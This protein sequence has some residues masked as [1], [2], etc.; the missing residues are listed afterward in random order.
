M[1]SGKDDRTD[2]IRILKALKLRFW[3]VNNIVLM[4]MEQDWFHIQN[5]KDSFKLFVEESSDSA[6][7]VL[8]PVL[9]GNQLLLIEIQSL[10][11]DQAYSYPQKVWLGINKQKL[12]IIMATL[13][14]SLKISDLKEKDLFVKV[15][16][17]F[18][19]K[20]IHLD[21]AVACSIISSFFNI[22]FKE[23]IFIGELGLSWEI[24]SIPKQKE[25]KERLIKMWFKEKYIIDRTKAS[26]L[27]ILLREVLKI[28][29]SK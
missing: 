24:R 16:S 20:N 13:H 18:Q 4:K 15:L 11:E 9:E 21:L 23:Y 10:L 14:K 1:I 2:S 22:N 6:W 19:F 25:I 3:N 28:W 8:C 5:P 7:S 29:A 17:P 26:N 12:D 27:P